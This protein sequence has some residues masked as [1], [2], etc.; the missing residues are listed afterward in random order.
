MTDPRLH[1]AEHTLVMAAPAQVVYD[2][3]ADATRWPAI[4][5]PSLYVRHIERSGHRERFQLWAI[6]NGE[7]K[8]WTSRRALDRGG[9]RVWFQQERSQAP[10][11]SMGGEWRFR[12]LPDGRTE[13]VLM[14]RFSTVGDDPE[15]VAWINQALDRNGPEELAALARIAELGHPI[16]DVVFAF[17]DVVEIPGAAADV[18]EFIY[19]ADR[20]PELLPHVRRVTLREE[21]PGVQDLETETVTAGGSRHTTRSVRV[22]FPAERIVLKQVVVPALLLGHS[23]RWTFRE[24]ADGT[25]VTACHTVAINPAA[26]RDALGPHSTLADAKKRITD[27][28]STNNLATL[29]HA[30][31]YATARRD[32]A[33]DGRAAR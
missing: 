25:V 23:G 4:F 1:H 8:T 26:L 30:S 6:V 33:A 22:C 9:L 10:T 15:A 16:D 14:H 29:A 21:R 18:Y 5:G 20:W 3:V 19:R 12:E 28:L 13:V 31:A 32:A 2:I 17:T 7:V 27:A 24:G 11:A